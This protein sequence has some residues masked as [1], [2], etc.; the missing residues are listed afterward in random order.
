MVS[1]PI[2]PNLDHLSRDLDLD[3]GRHCHSWILTVAHLNV[4]LPPLAPPQEPKRAEAERKAIAEAEKIVA[5]CNAGQSVTLDGE[6]VACDAQ[7]VTD[8][9]LLRSGV[10]PSARFSSTPSTCSN[11]M[12]SI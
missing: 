1:N 7:G 10:P 2:C 5:I 3:F 6:G 9:E 12:A 4:K 8:F 11:S